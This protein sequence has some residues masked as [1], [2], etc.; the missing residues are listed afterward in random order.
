MNKKSE[1]AYRREL[2][3]EQ[4]GRK[5]HA[6][7]LSSCNHFLAFLEELEAQILFRRCYNDAVKI[8]GGAFFRQKICKVLRQGGRI[9]DLWSIISTN[10]F[11]AFDGSMW[12][13]L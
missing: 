3:R 4:A 8:L 12:L 7:S 6:A 5:K 1:G 13:D 2:C 9:F 11:Y 10:M